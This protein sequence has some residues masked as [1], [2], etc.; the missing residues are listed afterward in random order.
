MQLYYYTIIAVVCC[1]CCCC[2][3]YLFCVSDPIV[4]TPVITTYTRT[5]AEITMN[6]FTR[7]IGCRATTVIGVELNSIQFSW[8]G[9]SGNVITNTTRVSLL[10]KHQ[11]QNNFSSEVLFDYITEGDQGIYTCTVTIL[12]VRLSASLNV[13]PLILS[14]LRRTCTQ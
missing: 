2:T 13:V 10:P 7:L 1:C 6:D 9:P 3:V 5:P 14:E 4:P 12:D 8:T 11:H